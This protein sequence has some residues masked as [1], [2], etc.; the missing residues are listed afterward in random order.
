MTVSSDPSG[1]IT[2][3]MN[4]L[5]CMWMITLPFGI[6]VQNLANFIGLI[7]MVMILLQSKSNLTQL[8]SM[9]KSIKLAWLALTLGVVC[10]IIG[11]LLNES[12]D[13]HLGSFL[14]GR[15]S[16]IIFPLVIPL[17][18]RDMIPKLLCGRKKLFLWIIL[19]WM[20]IL[21][22]QFIFPWSIRESYIA[23]GLG[24]RPEGFY[25]NALT[26]A[27]VLF[28]TYPLVLV[29]SFT[30]K[31][32]FWIACLAIIAVSLAVNN[33]R[34][35]LG[36]AV[37]LLGINT[38]IYLKGRL[39]ILVILTGAI[40]IGV[41][42][43]TENPISK[44]INVLLDQQETVTYK[45]YAD[46]R[47]V[48]WDIYTDMIKEKPYFGHGPKLTSAYHV[49]YYEARGFGDFEKKYSAHNQYL[50]IAGQSGLFGLFFFFFWMI[51]FS[52][53]MAKNIKDKTIRSIC[54]QSFIGFMFAGLTQ[55]A[56]QD[57]EVRQALMLL[58]TVAI[59]YALS[60]Q[61]QGE[62]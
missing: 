31:N 10:S 46:H 30:T 53:F 58:C 40:I 50:Q 62:A 25:S 32:K 48:F 22:S 39:R 33:S 54:L 36:V 3:K 23:L 9:P 1:K 45:G 17:L 18:G 13:N 6:A 14:A 16:L 8:T 21:V 27:Y 51:L 61:L 34:M 15:L 41:T 37:I 55:N 5:I 43:P 38:L 49:P 12:Y 29:K 42:L 35:I 59:T 4:F 44:R 57:A 24:H 7:I 60:T 20:V 56:F 19:C 2:K 26:L 11:G 52:I 28:F 47:L